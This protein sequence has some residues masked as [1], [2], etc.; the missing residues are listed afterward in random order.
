[1]VINWTWC[2]IIHNCP[3]S[4]TYYTNT[5]APDRMTMA[6]LTKHPKFG[7]GTMVIITKENIE[8]AEW[9]MILFPIINDVKIPLRLRFLPTSNMGPPTPIKLHETMSS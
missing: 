3:W 8:N 2:F 5:V 7:S 9:E 6:T 1:M 4:L